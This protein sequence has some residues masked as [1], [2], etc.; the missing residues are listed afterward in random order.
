MNVAMLT[1]KIIETDGDQG[2]FYY[3]IP[4][5]KGILTEEETQYH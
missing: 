2:T 5:L 4:W 1:L 3:N